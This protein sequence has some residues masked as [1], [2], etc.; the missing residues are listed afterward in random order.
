MQRMNQSEIQ[1]ELIKALPGAIGAIVAL[2]WITGPPLQRI[3]ALIGGIGASYY[4]ASWSARIMGTDE[5][6]AGFLIGLF[7]MAIASKV[8]E[9][10]A[11]LAPADLVSR[12]L[13]KFGL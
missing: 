9:A 4:A 6:L 1:P 7:G 8:F 12:I 13:R 2:R 10:I 5:G 11:V 3:A